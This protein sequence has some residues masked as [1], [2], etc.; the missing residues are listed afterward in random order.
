MGVDSVICSVDHHEEDDKSKGEVRREI[1]RDL[2]VIG[3]DPK[4]DEAKAAEARHERWK[5]R[6][7]L[8]SKHFKNRLKYDATCPKSDMM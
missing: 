4:R 7:L 3:K 8:S 6:S 5:Q 1:V 2:I